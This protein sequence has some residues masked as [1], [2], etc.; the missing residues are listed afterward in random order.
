MNNFMFRA[1]LGFDLG[2]NPD[3]GMKDRRIIAQADAESANVRPK[4]ARWMMRIVTLAACLVCLISGIASAGQLFTLN[5]LSDAEQMFIALLEGATWL[6]AS[7]TLGV[8]L[9]VELALV[10]AWFRERSMTRRR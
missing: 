4:A 9:V 6:L 10:R 5:A 2:R 8:W 1:C 3:Q 7:I